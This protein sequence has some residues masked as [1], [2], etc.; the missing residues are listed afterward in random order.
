MKDDYKIVLHSVVPETNGTRLL[1]VRAED[2]I[3]D[4]PV[5]A[6]HV[7]I[8]RAGHTPDA[9]DRYFVSPIMVCMDA[10]SVEDLGDSVYFIETCNRAGVPVLWEE[11]FCASFH[12][13]EDAIRHA[14]EKHGDVC[15][16][17]ESAE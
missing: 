4:F 2:F 1:I 11:P 15:K 14:V 17:R 12:S 7:E 10:P 3:E 8:Q 6:W 13:R 5:I 9:P 16:G